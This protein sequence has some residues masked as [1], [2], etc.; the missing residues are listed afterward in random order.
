MADE[1]DRASALEID[2][3]Q[4]ALS[5]HLNRVK[6]TPINHGFCDDCGAVIPTLRLASLPDAV[7]CVS[8][9]E[10]R[11]LQEAQRGLGNRQR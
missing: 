6:T 3:R 2:D 1:F 5:A 7:C 11:E 4:R 8:C 9:Q 10:I